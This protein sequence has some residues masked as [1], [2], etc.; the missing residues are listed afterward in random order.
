[1]PVPSD[2]LAYN[3]ALTSQKLRLTKI[4]EGTESNIETMKP[5]SLKY[6]LLGVS[7]CKDLVCTFPRH[8]LGTSFMHD[9]RISG[10]V[11]VGFSLDSLLWNLSH[12]C[13]GKEGA[14]PGSTDAVSSTTS[15]ILPSCATARKG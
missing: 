7:L 2:G 8:S 1:M 6:L 5:K 9:R 4:T 14:F 11:C 10:A 3:L 15:Y 13:R 12:L